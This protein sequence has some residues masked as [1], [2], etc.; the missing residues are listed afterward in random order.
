MNSTK[1]KILIIVFAILSM[2]IA[3][4]ALANGA[5][6][7]NTSYAFSSWA[8]DIFVKIV[9]PFGKLAYSRQVFLIRRM[10][11]ALVYFCFGF[12]F[13]KFIVKVIGNGKNKKRK[14]INRIISFFISLA[15]SVGLSCCDEL[16]IQAGTAGRTGTIT[17]VLFDAIFYTIAIAISVIY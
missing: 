1:N 8:L 11:H 9:P 5:A 6:D 3:A 15:V 7:G 2:A 12:F 13:S 4:F 10:A 16:I 14:V 17:D